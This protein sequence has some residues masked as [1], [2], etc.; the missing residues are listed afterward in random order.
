MVET[1]TKLGTWGG[2]FGRRSK[3]VKA[4]AEDLRALVLGLHPDT[5]EVPR[6]G[7]KAVSYGFGEKKMSESY[8]YLMPHPD[9]VNLGLWWGAMLDDPNALM[10]GT[11]KKLRHVKIFDQETARSAKIAHLVHTAIEERRSGLE[12]AATAKVKKKPAAK[13]TAKKTAVKKQ[14]AKAKPAKKVAPK[15]PAAA[16]KSTGKAAPKKQ[17]AKRKTARG[18]MAK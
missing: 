7:D 2:V 6:K 15:K 9:R 13:K 3:K 1:I 14:A 11:G 10:E 12:G 4:I 5:V 17:A 16:T 8:L 18:G